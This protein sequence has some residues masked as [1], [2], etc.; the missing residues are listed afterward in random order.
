MKRRIVDDPFSIY[1]LTWNGF[2]VNVYIN[3]V[4]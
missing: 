2:S 4:Y 3:Q 1:S